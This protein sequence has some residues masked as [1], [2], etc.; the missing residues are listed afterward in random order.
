VKAAAKPFTITDKSGISRQ[1]SEGISCS[2]GDMLSHNT[3]GT[4]MVLSVK[5]MGGDTLIEIAFEKYGTK[6]LMANFAKLIK[7]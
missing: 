7:I 3:F 5:Q 1:K 2:A 4:G 6:K